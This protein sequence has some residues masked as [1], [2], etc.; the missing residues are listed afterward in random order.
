[1]LPEMGLPISETWSYPEPDDSW[2]IELGEFI[3]DIQIGSSKSD[4]LDSSLE[5]L[6]VIGDIYSRT[7]R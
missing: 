7:S 1:M 2:E 3:N 4:N 6:R 5:V